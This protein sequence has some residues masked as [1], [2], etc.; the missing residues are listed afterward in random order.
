MKTKHLVLFASAMLTGFSAVAQT[1]GNDEGKAKAYMVADAHL[2]TQWNWD[3]KTTI[4]KY[5][6]NTL[7][8]NLFLLEHYP[9]YV[10]NFEGGVKYSWMKEYYPE[11]YE[12]LKEY[13]KNGRWHISGSSWEA[14]DALVPSTEAFIRNIMLGQTY[15]R[16][17]FGTE[18]TDIF[19][20]DCFGFGWNLPTVAAHCGLIGFS[21]QKLDWRNKPFYGDSK[22][23]F[24]IGLWQGVDGSRIMLAHGYDYGRKWKDE[25]LS[26]SGY[27]KE[28]ASRTPL[29]TVYRY[30]GTGD[31]GGSPTMTSVRA[32][33]RGVHGNGPVEVISAAS[34]QLFRDYLP[35]ASHP[36]LPVFD[37]E[38][39][40]DV[41]GTGCYTSQAAMKMYN[42]QN[43]LLG[44]AAE[45]AALA[46]DWLGAESYP[47]GTLT[48]SWRRFIFHQF[49]DDLTGT[50]IPR[51]YEFS[52]NDEL[53]SLKQFSDVLTNSVS[54]VAAMMDTRVKG[55]PVV[56][57]NANGF[58]V[59]D[60][61]EVTLDSPKKKGFQVYDAHGRKVPSQVM[62]YKDGKVTVLVEATVPANGYAVYDFRISGGVRTPS[63]KSVGTVENGVY[64]ISF[65]ANGDIVS[66]VDL[67]EDKEL[68]AEGK[69]IRLA[70][71]TENKSYAWPAWEVLKETVDREPVSI[72]E[73]VK[74]SLVEDGAVRRTVCVEKRYG[75]SSFRQYIRLYKG[76]LADR[77]DFY[78]EVD[79][80]TMNALLK[81]EF[82][83][84]VA[85]EKAVYDLGIGSVAR[86]NNTDTAYEVY[87]HQ[88]TDLT[89][90]DGSYGVSVLNDGKYGWDKPSD[91]NIRLTL[92]HT[93]QTRRGYAY[94]DRQDLGYHTFTY[95]LT[96]HRGE[97][98]KA[99]VSEKSDVLNQPVKA[100]VS[101]EHRG[102]LGKTF[103]FASSDN[104]NVVIKALKKAEMSD[105][106]I[107]RVYE[108]GGVKAQNAEITFAGDI[109]EA[110]EAD[111]TEKTT[112][113]ASFDGN[114]LQVSLGPN[115]IK[116]FKVVLK[117]NH[118][119]QTPQY[120]ALP[121]EYNH[122]CFSWN[123]FRHEVNFGSG[124]SYAAELLPE[125]EI[126]SAGVP[127]VIGDKD[128]ENGVACDGRT[129]K[130]PAGYNR[131]YVLAASSEADNTVGF[132]IG[133][134]SVEVNVPFFGGFIGQW[135]HLGHTDGF[136]KAADVA[137]VGTHS[138][139]TV[140]DE[141]Y[142]FT[143][144]FRYAF[145]IPDGADSVVLPDNRGVVVFAMTVAD[146]SC[147]DVVPA[148]EL[149]R[150]AIKDTDPSSESV[151][152]VNLLKDAKIIGYSGYAN[153][154]EMPAFAVDG[155]VK[156]KWCDAGA[157]PYHLDFDLGQVRTI[158]GWK[159]VNA[160]IEQMS[161]V[162][163]G[164]YL[165]GRNSL[166]ED[167]KTI[168]GIDGNR[169]DVVIR[170][171]T[172]AE[173]RYIRLFVTGP[174]Q[175][176]GQGV[177]RIYEIEVY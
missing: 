40:M 129:V 171:V 70:L 130:L 48:D 64:R 78:N 151:Q 123:A 28:L 127:F 52:W 4:D 140:G 66:L 88:W 22:H 80:N 152:K 117:K 3:I 5:V 148:S 116:T 62:D 81:A 75:E 25:D 166:S 159:L 76:A 24:T 34:D 121:L 175:S 113:D 160:G 96:G 55:T 165:Q 163:R 94:Q 142:E 112:G 115:C 51:A 69:A 8:Q 139:S 91:N 132:K 155:D 167:W 45:R 124:Y 158:S 136:L 15:Y 150:T 111:G 164:C 92:L 27:L 170:D 109:L 176:P 65:D 82:P 59:T 68:V 110:F 35:F 177:A 101:S 146:E 74:V 46:A 60:V 29:N 134:M 106:Y 67:R 138:H 11:Q 19:L 38:L 143:Y 32:V 10:F 168:D 169:K 39:L 84:A 13:V 44:D 56:F 36:E 131:L 43:E 119:A 89:D 63:R 154:R 53:L 157:A 9:D 83:L 86:G 147:P 104:P 21:S 7:N 54:G 103:S 125:N 162:T 95:S 12:K 17:E 128:A 72:V 71:F 61:V 105:E 156:T 173:Y 26:E 87:S 126:V 174:T 90:A 77:I 98:D 122:K 85:N 144:M 141:S 37:G 33:E 153:D 42:R 41:H 107:V 149:F 145:D 30:Y 172:P 79:W 97:L 1:S 114:K 120:K 49:H 50:S 73:D 58:A 2:D 16:Q 57:Y 93:P 102:V 137:Y 6:W 20:P 31:I 118:K 18:S 47:S 161:Y 14:S 133:N 135:G 99:V 23:P 108:K 100:F